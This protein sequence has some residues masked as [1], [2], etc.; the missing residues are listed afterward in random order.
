MDAQPALRICPKCKK[1][2]LDT[3]V[4]RSRLVKIFAFW[5]PLK[6]YKC[7]YCSKKSYFREED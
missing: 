7:Y 5:L 4:P 3:R 2:V 6:R 1:G